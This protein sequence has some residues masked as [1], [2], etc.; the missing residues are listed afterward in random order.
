MQGTFT[1]IDFETANPSSDSACAIGLVR[2]ENNKIVEKEAFL[3][4]PPTSFFTFTYIHGLTWDQVMN[5]P[6]FKALWPKL[7]P[8]FKGVDFLAAHNASFDRRVLESTCERYELTAPKKPYVCTVQVA[9][10]TWNIRPTRLPNVCDHLG[11]KL[12][13]HDALS[14]A[15][16]CAQILIEARKEKPLG[17]SPQA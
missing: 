12:N 13:H 1:A 16:A 14:D 9:R 5:A 3:I 8:Y 6:D 11:I 2:V 7:T 17:K 10:S 15:L 4:R